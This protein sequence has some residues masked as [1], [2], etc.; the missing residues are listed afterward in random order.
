MMDVPGLYPRAKGKEKLDCNV[1]AGKVCS[2]WHTGVPRRPRAPGSTGEPATPTSQPDRDGP[3]NWD[4]R[5]A[6]QERPHFCN[7]LLPCQYPTAWFQKHHSDSAS[8]DLCV[9]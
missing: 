6:D 1:E 3:G 8:R 7:Q 2:R 4:S 9:L 5:R